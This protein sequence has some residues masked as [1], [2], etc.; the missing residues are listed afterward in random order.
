M[1]AAAWWLTALALRPLQRVA[2]GVRER[3]EQSLEPLPSRRA[4]RGGG[5]AGHG[6][7]RAA[8]APGPVAGHAARLRRRCR[9]RVA[10]AADSAEAAAAAAQACAS[11]DDRAAAGHR[12]TGRRHRARDATRRASCSTLAR[13]RTRAPAV[14]SFRAGSSC[15]RAGERST[16]PTCE[17]LAT[18]SA[19]ARSE[20]HAR[21]AAGAAC[22]ATGRRSNAA[23][24]Q[25]GRQRGALF[26][27]GRTRSRCRSVRRMAVP[28]VLQ[29]DDAGPGIPPAERDRVFDRFYRR[30]P[31]AEH[32]QRPRPGY[33]AQHRATAMVQRVTLDDSALGGLARDAALL[34]RKRVDPPRKRGVRRAVGYG[35][36]AGLRASLWSP[37]IARARLAKPTA[38][39]D[40]LA[41]HCRVRGAGAPLPR[42]ARPAAGL[43]DAWH[44]RRP[45]RRDRISDRKRLPL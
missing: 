32:R 17:P 42:P 22:A 34:C 31:G 33:R 44:R 40:Q 39:A 20:P 19:A 6:A 21:R 28:R 36:A 25:P 2:A 26:A 12:R 14:T 37:S 24:A 11:D 10:L 30:D 27:A 3:D 15:M 18:W 7:E 23:G 38:C 45:V 4:A 43:G 9:A 13:T 5:A 8:A 1:A 35:L 16:W 29:V 41:L